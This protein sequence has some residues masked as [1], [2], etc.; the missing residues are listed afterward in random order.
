MRP[1]WIDDD[2]TMRGD[3]VAHT[4]I[5][6]WRPWVHYLVSTFRVD[7]SSPTQQ[8]I[9]SLDSQQSSDDYFVT[10]VVRCGRYGVARPESEPL[11]ERK[12]RTVDEARAGHDEAVNAFAENELWLSVCEAFAQRQAISRGPNRLFLE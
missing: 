3:R 12:Y 10:R 6:K 8:M 9:R 5:A 7:S 11:L 4:I 1:R 2:R